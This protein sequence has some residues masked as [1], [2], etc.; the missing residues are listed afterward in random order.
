MTSTG[1][2]PWASP[3]V[4]EIVPVRAPE[5]VTVAEP[6]EGLAPLANRTRIVPRWR[7]DGGNP[8]PVSVT[9][10]PAVPEFGDATTPAEYPGP[11]TPPFPPPGA[12]EDE[13]ESVVALALVGVLTVAPQAAAHPS[14]TFW[15]SGV[16]TL[17]ELGW[18]AADTEEVLSLCAADG[19]SALSRPAVPPAIA[20]TARTTRAFVPIVRLGIITSSVSDPIWGTQG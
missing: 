2:D 5:G 18:C 7:K 13:P 11:G 6:N 15:T 12:P 4:T 17:G 10:V 9:T 16:T 1:F 20:T 19:C 8:V 3:E 14:R